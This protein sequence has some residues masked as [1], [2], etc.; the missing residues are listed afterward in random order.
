MNSSM[1]KP[2]GSLSWAIGK[3]YLGNSLGEVFEH[4]RLIRYMGILLSHEIKTGC[5]SCKRKKAFIVLLLYGFVYHF[6][7]T[8]NA[9]TCCFTTVR[10]SNPCWSS[11]WYPK[12]EQEA[13][14]CC[15]CTVHRQQRETKKEIE[16]G[17]IRIDTSNYFYL[18]LLFGHSF[19]IKFGQ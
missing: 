17:Q 16:I 11:C 4:L 18:Q 9:C 6:S 19:S 13:L 1:R 10:S 14:R 5:E 8:T 12:N 15:T 2:L 7:T 3:K